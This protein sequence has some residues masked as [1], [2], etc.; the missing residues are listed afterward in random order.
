MASLIGLHFGQCGN[1]I[2]FDFWKTLSNE[3]GLTSN[4]VA[5]ESPTGGQRND[6]LDVFF[7]EGDQE[8]Y[9][10]RAVM[11]D[12]EPRVINGIFQSDYADF[13][14]KTSSFMSAD[15]GGAGNNWA[16]GYAQ[17]Q[18]VSEDVLELIRLE[19][20]RADDLEGF[21]VTHSVSGGTGSG[22]GSFFIEKI[23]SEYPKKVI[24]TY[25]VFANQAGGTSDVIV[26]PY[27]SILTLARLI[28]EADG[29]V[30]LDNTALH[31][32]AGSHLRATSSNKFDHINYLVSRIMSMST[33]TIRFP[34]PLF[35]RMTSMLATL[36]PF[37]PL[38][39]LQT[40]MHPVVDPRDAMDYNG[41]TN[42]NNVLRQ[43]LRPINLMISRP[44]HMSRSYQNLAKSKGVMLSGLAIM[45]GR[46]NNEDFFNTTT[47]AQAMMRDEI[48]K[49]A[50]MDHNPMHFCRAPLSPFVETKVN[51][52]GMMLANHTSAVTLLS[53]TLHQYSAMRS[54]NAYID[55]F[56]NED[57]FHLDEMDQSAELVNDIIEEYKNIENP[58]FF[59]PQ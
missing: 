19:A 44:D 37:A 12:L 22:L 24:Q 23:R 38:R 40:S 6:R 25:S 34:A 41:K 43:L 27:N 1:Q 50:W 35:S 31:H 30:I 32:I 56:K 16:S 39:F 14:K 46:I 28:Q 11:V 15:G 47:A 42:I 49:P 4:G 36:I 53:H 18:K 29:V 57:G 33:A 13:F 45:Q 3:H 5:R 54:K 59:Q 58:E 10:P 8:K 7:S 51:V 52:S 55:R 48:Q 9:I 21:M 20:E 26:S 2:G 17:G